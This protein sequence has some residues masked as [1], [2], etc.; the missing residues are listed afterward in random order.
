MVELVKCRNFRWSG[1]FERIEGGE[2]T[3]RIHNSGVNPVNARG[4]PPIKWESSVG[5]L[6]E[7]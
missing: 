2:L 4:R 6:A 5:T 3:K 7:D 1:H